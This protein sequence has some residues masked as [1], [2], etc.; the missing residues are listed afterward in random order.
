MF[1][2]ILNFFKGLLFFTGSYS[3]N[4]FPPPLT[5]DE[6]DEYIKQM[7]LGNKEARN[8]LIEHNLRLVAH[9]VKKFESTELLADDLISIG[10]IGLIKGID[11]Y[12]PNKNIKITTY[13][14]KCAEN[15]I[16]MFFRANKRHCND[17]SLNDCVGVDKEGN[18]ITLVDVLPSQEDDLGNLIAKKTDIEALIKY[19]NVLNKREKEIIIKRYALFDS[20]Q[21]T[22]KDIANLMN[23][24][25]S[26]VSRIEKRAL[27]KLYKE[28][29]K[30]EKKD[31]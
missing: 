24:S 8:K 6:E 3:V 13:I 4:V 12:N 31:L 18:E 20:N 19:L 21:Y 5:K 30:H 29:Y 15:E 23:I 10:T 27:T 25:R 22:Q 28:F 16:L 14:A 9:L 1:F 17:V 11:S 2:N 26:Y 7:L